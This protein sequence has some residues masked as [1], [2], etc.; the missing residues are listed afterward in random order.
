MPVPKGSWNGYSQFLIFYNI[1][2][3]PGCDKEV[4]RQNRKLRNREIPDSF[5][6]K[7]VVLL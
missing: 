7:I 6:R 5:M 2:G 3:R 1:V 4:I